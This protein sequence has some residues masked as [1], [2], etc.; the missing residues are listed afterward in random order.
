MAAANACGSCAGPPGSKSF[1]GAPYSALG[2]LLKGRVKSVCRY[3]AAAKCSCEALGSST[4]MNLTGLIVCPEWWLQPTGKSLWFGKAGFFFSCPKTQMKYVGFFSLRLDFLLC[5][6]GGVRRKICT[7]GEK[8]TVDTPGGCVC[9]R[10]APFC[11]ETGRL[12]SKG[13][14]ELRRRSLGRAPGLRQRSDAGGQGPDRSF[15]PVGSDLPNS[16]PRVPSVRGAI[17]CV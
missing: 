8:R 1:S 15:A 13:I 9:R 14:E 4:P 6:V 10:A 11:C 12:F 16:A 2:E 3:L 17:N 7:E 5:C